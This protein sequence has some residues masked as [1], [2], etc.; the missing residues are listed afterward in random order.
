MKKRIRAWVALIV[1]LLLFINVLFI[2]YRVTESVIIL[3]F[4]VLF[5]F[6]IKRRNNAENYAPDINDSDEPDEPDGNDVENQL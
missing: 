4:Y 1:F 3:L 5:F 6:I 2:H